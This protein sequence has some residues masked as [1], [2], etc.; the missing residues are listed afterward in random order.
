MTVVILRL[1][2]LDVTAAMNAANQLL[3]DRDTYP[4]L[5]RTLVLDDT[6]AL[7][8]HAGVFQSLLSSRRLEHVLCV[9][10]GPRDPNSRGHALEHDPM[11]S[12]RIRIPPTISSGQGSAVLWVS[13]PRGIDCRLSAA[14]NADGHTGSPVDGLDCL[15]DVLSADDVYDKVLTLVGGLRDGVASPG[16]HLADGDD[17][18]AAFPAALAMAIARITGAG[19]GAAAGAETPFASLYPGATGLASLVPDGELASFR[20]RVA[21]AAAAI[22]AVAA[23]SPGGLFRKA[24][25]DIQGDVVAIGSDLRAFH[26][27]V[28]LL[29]TEAQAAGELTRAQRA[30]VAAAGVR[31]PIPIGRANSRGRA[32]QPGPD[33]SLV[34]WSVAEATRNGDTLPR[35]MRRLNL[36]AQQLKQVGSAAYLSE[37]D[38][39]CPAGLLSRLASP[40]ER[41][42]GRAAAEEWRRRLGLAEA[43]TAAENLAALVATVATR[44]WSGIAAV[45]D[46]VSRTRIALDGISKKLADHAATVTA[47]AVSGAR[48]A[49]RARLADALTPILYDLVDTVIAAE[50]AGPSSGGQEAFERAQDKTA[51]LI[52]E[53]GRHAAEHGATSRPSFAVSTVHDHMYAGDDVA[54]LRETLLHDP[55]QRMW[56]LCEPGDLGVLDVTQAPRVVAFASRMDKDALGGNLPDDMTWTASGSHAGLLRLVPLRPGTVRADWADDEPSESAESAS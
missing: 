5:D 9:G 33:P 50:S 55:V 19:S 47:P 48:A 7:V 17:E 39:I 42:S 53:W 2:G 54:T 30:A 4:Y 11:E 51:G 1:R 16:L 38:K 56:Q 12:H 49:R 37:V 26:D 3:A 29:F 13:D 41:P 52:T 46:E 8:S 43:A 6:R 14:A 20:D 28:V 24:A 36:T 34:R 10:V 27:R 23:K 35:V 25:P 32:D 22:S 40:A 18:A 21:G 44:E 15:V 45:A 31:L